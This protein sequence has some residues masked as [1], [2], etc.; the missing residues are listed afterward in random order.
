MLVIN[1]N[2]QRLPIGGH[3]F[4]ENN[5]PVIRGETFDEVEDK[6]SKY[7][8]NNG[9]PLGNPASEIIAYYARNFPWMVTLADDKESKKQSSNY[10]RFSHWIRTVWK[11]PPRKLIHQK[12]AEAR[13]AACLKCPRNQK[14]DWQTTG[15]AAE[16][17]RRSFMLRCGIDIPQGLGFCSCHKAPLEVFV[18]VEN[19]DSFSAKKDEEPK[20]PGCWV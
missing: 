2:Q 16:M 5:G 9:L 6:L 13:W 4:P 1:R 12:E 11:N 15:E 19:A 7:R 8:I 18:F 20:Q 10:L 17:E 14:K 3:H